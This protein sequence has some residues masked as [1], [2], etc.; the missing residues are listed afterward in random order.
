MSG[1]KARN[2]A[3]SAREVERHVELVQ[4]RSAPAVGTG[5][6]REKIREKIKVRA[7]SRKE[8]AKQMVA[9]SGNG[10]AKKESRMIPAE[11]GGMGMGMNVD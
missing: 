10:K 3:E 7:A 11:G 5:E 6:E 2:L 8:M 9:K 1:N 4:P